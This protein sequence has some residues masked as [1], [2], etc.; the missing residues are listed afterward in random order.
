MGTMASDRVSMEAGSLTSPVQTL[1]GTTGRPVSNTRRA[2]R[3][4]FQQRL[5]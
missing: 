3:R 1:E 4:F 5:A 2:L